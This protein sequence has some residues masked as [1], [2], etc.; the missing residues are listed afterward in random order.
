VAG[1]TLITG[2]HGLLGSWVRRGWSA[3]DGELVVVDH[4]SADLL[5]PGVPA[6]I[7]REVQPARVVHLAWSASGTP[8]Y[9]SSRANDEWVR[10]TLELVAAAAD[11]RATIWATGTVVDRVGEAAPPSDDDTY[12]AAKR[13]LRARLSD[14]I[15]AKEIGWLRPFY[16]FDQTLRRPEVVAA[17]MAARDEGR[18]V[19]LRTPE[20]AHDFVHAADVGQ[21][22]LGAL[23]HDLRGPVDIGSGTIRS[24]AELVTALG[25]TWEHAEGAQ[26]AADAHREVAADSAALRATGWLPTT[27]QELFAA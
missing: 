6:R 15:A 25:L 11:V 23:R 24:V 10:A 5:E 19:Q 4:A 2:A 18:P 14:R 9:R 17:A 1:P 20:A 7:V 21:A 12:S 22:I 8:G 13:E 3:E 27:T 26:P 16:V